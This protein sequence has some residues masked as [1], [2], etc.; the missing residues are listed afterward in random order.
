MCN[1]ET[2]IAETLNSILIQINQYTDEVIIVDDCSTDR[3]IEIVN[4]FKN[5]YN[6]IVFFSTNSRSG[7]PAVPRNLAIRKSRGIYIAFCDS[8]DIWHPNKIAIQIPF[9]KKFDLVCSDSITFLHNIPNIKIRKCVDF[10]ELRHINFYVGNPISN[11]SVICRSEIIKKF[12]FN[13]SK[14]LIAVE[15]FDLWIKILLSNAD[16]VKI[17]FPLLFYRRSANQISRNKFKMAKKNL[18]IYIKN[19]GRFKGFFFHIFYISFSLLKLINRK[20]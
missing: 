20:F 2:Y 15:D 12:Y 7:G 9:L 19:F 1:A 3:S 14:E 5:L 16:M 10:I 17:T 13:E 11:S 8:D 4:R 6:C 18:L